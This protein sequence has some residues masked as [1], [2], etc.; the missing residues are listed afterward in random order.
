MTSDDQ[1]YTAGEIAHIVGWSGKGPRSDSSLSSEHRNDY[2]NLLLLCRNHHREIDEDEG[3]YPVVVLQGWKEEDES[4]Y[5]ER[6]AKTDFN[7][8][9]LQ[10]VTQDL[11][12]SAVGPDDIS[13]SITPLRAKMA[14]NELGE[15]SASLFQVGLLRVG[16]VASFIQDMS[17]VSSTFVDRLKHGFI[18]EYDRLREEGVAGDELFEKLEDFSSQGHS[19]L[20]Y[21][22]ASLSVLVYLFERCEIFERDGDQG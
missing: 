16:Q 7:F 6:L 11:L 13:M 18:T 2:S 9:E 10:I 3:K 17:G 1:P 5:R 22:S 20:R 21:R 4:R 12:G 15:R 14:V 8:R 19:D